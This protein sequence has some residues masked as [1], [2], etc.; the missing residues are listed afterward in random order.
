MSRLLVKQWVSATRQGLF[1]VN[2][3]D[4]TLCPLDC[5]NDAQDV[6]VGSAT[7]TKDGRGLFFTSSRDNEFLSLRHM[8]LGDKPL[9][10]STFALTC[11]RCMSCMQA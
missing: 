1:A 3:E 8:A 2:L 10:S 11:C 5:G 4:G 6:A 7:W 9:A